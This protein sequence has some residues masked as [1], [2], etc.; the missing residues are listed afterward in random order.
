MANPTIDVAFVQEFEA[1]VHEAYQRKGSIFR[2]CCRKRSGVKN[3][4]TF[5]KYGTGNATQKARNAVIPPMNNAHTNVSVTVE[6]WYA[7]DFIDELDELRI[8]HDEMQAS[9]N[10][11]AYALGRKTDDQIIAALAAGAL[12]N[13]DEVTNGATLAWATAVMVM[14]GN[15]DVPDDGDRYGIVGWEQWGK[16][17]AIPQ[18]SNSQYVG[19]DDLPF[20]RGTQAKRW[21]SIMWMPWSGYVRGTNT[22]NYTFHRSA[23]GHAIGQDVNSTITYEGTR[24]AWWAL[25]KMQMN[26][27]VIDGLGVV[28]SSLKVA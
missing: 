3:K 5:Q 27:V 11:G 17:L 9:M 7:G 14:M 21:L 19:T 16:L 12:N 26:A 6:D 24:A 23:V 2:A 18:F 15:N 8:N 13:V 4:T 22:T 10:A 28:Q 1:G 20:Q 25:N